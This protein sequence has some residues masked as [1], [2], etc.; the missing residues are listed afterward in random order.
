[1]RLW[2]KGFAA[3]VV[4]LLVLAA[5][6]PARATSCTAQA[7]LSPRIVRLWRLPGDGWPWRWCNRTTPP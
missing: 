5:S 7:E 3:P 6:V 2:W 1:M 4:L